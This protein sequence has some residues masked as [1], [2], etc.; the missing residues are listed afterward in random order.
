MQVQMGDGHRAGT[1]A[2][3]VRIQQHENIPSM[4]VPLFFW[5]ISSGKH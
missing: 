3:G 5:D 4:V 2:T 1:K